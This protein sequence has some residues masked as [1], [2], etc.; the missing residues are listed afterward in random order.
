MASPDSQFILTGER[1]TAPIDSA[2]AKQDVGGAGATSSPAKHTL[3][4]N[5]L[6]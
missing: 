4:Y 3:N 5:D 6:Q 2:A 1:K